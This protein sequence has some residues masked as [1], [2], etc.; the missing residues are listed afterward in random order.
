MKRL[1]FSY[2]N[3]LSP[4]FK[5]QDLDRG[6]TLISTELSAILLFRNFGGGLFNG[7]NS[8]GKA[9]IG[10]SGNSGKIRDFKLDQYYCTCCKRKQSK[11]N[12]CSHLAAVA[13]SLLREG[14]EGGK[15]QPNFSSRMTLTTFFTI[16]VIAISSAAT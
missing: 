9:M 13:I 11:G 5:E 6:W 10:L 15:L 3:T 2:K 12:Y 16:T 7:N 14:D 8:H 4:W 1:P